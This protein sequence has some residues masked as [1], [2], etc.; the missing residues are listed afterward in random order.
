MFLYVFFTK[1]IFVLKVFFIKNTFNIFLYFTKNTYLNATPT[2]PPMISIVQFSI[3]YHY[4]LS[5]C[6]IDDFVT[7]NR[8]IF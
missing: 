5:E 8:D 2:S 7:N 4:G 3:K 6:C 1:Y